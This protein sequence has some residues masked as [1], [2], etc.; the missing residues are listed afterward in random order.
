MIGAPTLLTRDGR[1]FWA[2]AFLA[3]AVAYVLIMTHYEA[4]IA[5]AE[6]SVNDIRILVDSA[7]E[8]I[9]GESRAVKRRAE[10]VDRLSGVTA[11]KSRAEVTGRF[12]ER[13]QALARRDHVEVVSM[14]HGGE[15]IVADKPGLAPPTPRPRNFLAVT[16]PNAPSAPKPIDLFARTFTQMPFGIRLTG[17]YRDIVRAV[18]DL[19]RMD[20]LARVDRATF[21]AVRNGE[22]QAEVQVVVFRPVAAVGAT[23]TATVETVR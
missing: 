18:A 5:D 12:L 8:F 1:P 21:T 15:V 4:R 9:T 16:A 22:L 10:L 23:Q 14:T 13:V 6:A 2:A 11:P 3:A 7:K 19:S 20:V 17:G